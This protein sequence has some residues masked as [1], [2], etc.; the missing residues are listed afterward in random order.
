MYS[1]AQIPDNLIKYSPHA[2]FNFVMSDPGLYS[3]VFVW[4]IEGL[5]AG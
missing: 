3:G 4:K 1:P 5:T 2:G